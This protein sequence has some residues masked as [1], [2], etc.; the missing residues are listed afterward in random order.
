MSRGET[1]ACLRIE[2]KK[3]FQVLFQVQAM[4]EEQL[5]LKV[6]QPEVFA[7]VSLLARMTWC[8]LQYLRFDS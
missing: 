8:V 3:G 2:Q 6:K 7:F 1:L 4:I 5:I